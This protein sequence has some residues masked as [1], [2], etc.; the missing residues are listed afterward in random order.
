[1]TVTPKFWKRS[2]SFFQL[3]TLPFLKA[4]MCL[5]YSVS[6][7][8][9]AR[10]PF[11]VGAASPLIRREPSSSATASSGLTALLGVLPKIPLAL[12]R[13]VNC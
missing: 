8:I 10:L 11:S 6:M 13:I 4:Y 7:G 9:L 3:V 2:V 12:I 1:V 5:S